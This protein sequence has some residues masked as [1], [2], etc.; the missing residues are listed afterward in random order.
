VSDRNPTNPDLLP[1]VYK[2]VELSSMI[3]LIGAGVWRST[4]LAKALHIDLSTI[5]EWKKRPEVQDA[6]RRAILKF[7]KRRTDVEKILS[8][9]DFETPTEPQGLTQIN[10]YVGLTD[11]QLDAVIAAKVGQI[12]AVEIAPGEGDAPEGKSS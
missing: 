11:D 12:G 1:D 10:N 4:N 8:E 7:A 3:E 5:A 6:H 2:Q 9:L